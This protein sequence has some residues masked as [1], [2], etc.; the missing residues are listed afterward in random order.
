MK[1][2]LD[3]I[4][5]MWLSIL[6]MVGL[7]VC[8]VT[9]ISAEQ[10]VVLKIAHQGFPPHVFINATSGHWAELIKERT[11]G[12]VELKMFYDTLAKGPGI[13]TAAQQGVADG[14]VVISTFLTG[15]VKAL[16]PLE[17]EVNAAPDRYPE[18]VKAIRPVMERIFVE[19]GLKYCG[20]MYSY[21]SVCYTNTKKHYHVP[22]DFKGLKIRQP[23]LWGQK[24][25]KIWGATP[26]TI[27]PPEL[28]TSAQRGIIDGVGAINMLVD[29]FKLYEVMPYITEM[30]NSMGAVVVFGLNM[31][32]FNKLDEK[33]QQIILQSAKE[34]ELF[35]YDYGHKQEIELKQ[36]LMKVGKYYVQTPEEYNAFLDISRTLIPEI[37]EFSGPLGSELMDIVQEVKQ[38]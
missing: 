3:L 30:P 12:E 38:K 4:K 6:L 21:D 11:N 23:G 28:Y 7:W 24:R 2:K 1:T 16:N 19:Q 36:K 8:P 22:D 20:S 10:P 37:R 29:V 9:A 25:I 18:L 14:Y 31:D 15:Q 34:A 5:I 26:V 17:I 35:S 13:L 33:Y 32:R 27:L